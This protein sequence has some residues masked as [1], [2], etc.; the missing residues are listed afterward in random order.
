[1]PSI[2]NFLEWVKS[3]FDSAPK[4]EYSDEETNARLNNLTYYYLELWVNSLNRGYHYTL[5]E[6]LPSSTVITHLVDVSHDQLKTY[7]RNIYLPSHPP[8]LIV[9]A[10]WFTNYLLL[11][12]KDITLEDY[13]T[14]APEFFEKFKYVQDELG[15]SA[16]AEDV[17]K[18]MQSLSALVM[19][20]R[21]EAKTKLGFFESQAS[22]DDE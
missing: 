22:S 16:S 2:N 1:M 17:L 18:V 21:K 13:K 3:I 20:K 4:N 19:K 7:I 14:Y 15:D 5:C 9:M 12:M 8:K 11:I 6:E 10:V